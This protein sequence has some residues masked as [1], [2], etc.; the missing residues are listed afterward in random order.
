VGRF[1]LLVVVC[2]SGNATGALS[3]PNISALQ[4]VPLHALCVIEVKVIVRIFGSKVKW[5]KT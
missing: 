2:L 3:F 4:S 5:L 1:V